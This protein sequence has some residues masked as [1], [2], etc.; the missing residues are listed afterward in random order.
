MPVIIAK[1][2]RR[3]TTTDPLEA[4]RNYLDGL[5]WEDGQRDGASW[6]ACLRAGSLEI[7]PQV[8][9]DEVSNRIT[10]SGVSPDL[11]KIRRQIQRAYLFATAQTAAI[12]SGTF[13]PTPKK[14][15]PEYDPSKLE[16]LVNRIDVAVTAE[17]LE[18]RSP[19]TCWNRTP[20][21][22]LH[23]LYRPGE[24]IVVFDVEMSQG[25]AIYEHGGDHE[26]FTCLDESEKVT[27]TC[28]FFRIP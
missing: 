9:F 7:D 23:A 19:L 15:K 13:Q 2:P 21:G 28:G 16:A 22:F 20:A 8:C 11:S 1:A 6:N 25:Q 4:W 24:K 26:D 14:P 10:A 5:P 3:P 17:W 12:Q 18:D 27:R